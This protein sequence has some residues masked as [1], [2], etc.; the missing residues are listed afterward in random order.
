M[1]W[2]IYEFP[3]NQK[4]RQSILM[5]MSTRHWAKHTTLHIALKL[6]R[7]GTGSEVGAAEAQTK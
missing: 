3:V 2:I 6:E 7:W 1:T 5:A 4:P